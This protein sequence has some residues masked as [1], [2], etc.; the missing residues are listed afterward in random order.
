MIFALEEPAEEVKQFRANPW[1]SQQTF[2]TPLKNLNKFVATLLDPFALE[3]ASLSTDEI[4]FE[5][6]RLLQLMASNSI[7]TESPWKFN[8]RASGPQSIAE[9]LEATLACWIDFAFVSTPEL[10]AIYADHDEY[11]TFYA[12][13]EAT[14]KDLASVLEQAGFERVDGYRR[15]S[16]DNWK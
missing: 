11:T 10:F 12:P 13:T 16:G 8:L 7:H 5:P 2:K 4:V 15:P 1:Q 14:V 3:A 6:D 9:F